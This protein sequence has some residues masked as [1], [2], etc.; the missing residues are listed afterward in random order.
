MNKNKNGVTLI[1][2]IITIIILLILAAVS[3]NFVVGDNGI[4]NNAMKAELETYKGEVRD[5][6]LLNLNDELLSCST[7]LMGGAGDISSK[8]NEIYLINF[9]AGN[10]NFAGTD[11][12]DTSAVKCI[13]KI[14]GAVAINT[15]DGSGAQIVADTSDSNKSFTE[16]K[17]SLISA[18]LITDDGKIYNK[19]RVIP[20]A[21]S[22]SGR[23]YGSGTKDSNIFILE[24]VD[25]SGNPITTE[26]ATSSGKF[27]L[28]YYDKD[29]K[30]SV[31][32]TVS[33]YM[34][35]QS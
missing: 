20:T 13:E 19:Y 5:Q 25:D 17:A 10:K 11:Y 32:E 34:T 4:L 9:L 24:A 6:L 18:G 16:K 30:P 35:N 22:N 27:N 12:E 7:A 28:V 33:L 26:G 2:L 14:S 1:A 8:Y 23:N 21:L 31:L 3:I 15:K 29:K